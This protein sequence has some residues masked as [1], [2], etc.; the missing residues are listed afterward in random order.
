[1]NVIELLWK[2][3]QIHDKCNRMVIS[4]YVNFIYIYGKECK[5]KSINDLAGNQLQLQLFLEMDTTVKV[6]SPCAGSSVECPL[7]GLEISNASLMCWRK[8]G[9]NLVEE[10][11]NSISGRSVA[12]RTDSTRLSS[13]LEKT[14]GKLSAKFS[15]AKGSWERNKIRSGTT[16]VTVG[17]GETVDIQAVEN[18]LQQAEV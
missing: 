13:L 11:N 15:K 17:S 6:V 3:T 16:H 10:V 2:S 7:L 12:I 9:K 18:Q 14:A 4:K 8:A 1:M 5:R